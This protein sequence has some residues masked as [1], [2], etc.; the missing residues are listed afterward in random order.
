MAG[1]PVV[2]FQ[3]KKRMRT[4]QEILLTKAEEEI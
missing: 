4:L 3:S 1:K 2:T